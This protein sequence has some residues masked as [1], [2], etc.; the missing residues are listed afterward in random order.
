M[1]IHEMGSS[2]RQCWACFTHSGCVIRSWYAAK[3]ALLV[4]ILAL[5][6]G[7]FARWFAL[8]FATLYALTFRANLGGLPVEKC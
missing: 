5:V 6:L 3:Y 7:Q 1:G 2:K 4:R 8:R